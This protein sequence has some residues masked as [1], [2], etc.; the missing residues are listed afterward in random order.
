MNVEISESPRKTRVGMSLS[1]E[2]SGHHNQM[3]GCKP[4]IENKLSSIFGTR[5]I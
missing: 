3:K 1:A 5:R 4:R 2:Q